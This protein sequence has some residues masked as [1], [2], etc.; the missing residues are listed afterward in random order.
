MSFGISLLAETMVGTAHV[1]QS[2][3]TRTLIMKRFHYI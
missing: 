3:E 2:R 1:K